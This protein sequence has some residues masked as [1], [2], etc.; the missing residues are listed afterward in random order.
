MQRKYHN[1][2]PKGNRRHVGIAPKLYAYLKSLGG[3]DGSGWTPEPG[4]YGTKARV[5]RRSE[6][7]KP[8]RK[9]RIVSVPVPATMTPEAFR[10]Y[11]VNYLRRKGMEIRAELRS[12]QDMSMLVWLR[13]DDVNYKEEFDRDR[14]RERTREISAVLAPL[15]PPVRPQPRLAPLWPPVK[16]PR[17]PVAIEISVMDIGDVNG[18]RTK[19]RI[20]KGRTLTQAVAAALD[21]LPQGKEIRMPVPTEHYG[22]AER[23]RRN[24]FMSIR[25]KSIRLDTR[26]ISDNEIAIW[27]TRLEYMYRE[28]RARIGV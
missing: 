25:R 7:L 16:E 10:V 1:L 11:I 9:P 17:E 3:S 15:W 20:Y 13:S 27:L 2:L 6:S 26:V 24:L 23:F 5:E 19:P 8:R 14:L 21:R 28:E 18:E 12:P 22:G 4:V